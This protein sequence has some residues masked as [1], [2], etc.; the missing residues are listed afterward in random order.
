MMN[1]SGMLCQF[2]AKWLKLTMADVTNNAESV[3]EG[4]GH[5]IGC[6]KN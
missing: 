5:G 3:Y 4:P 1:R 6:V 2:K